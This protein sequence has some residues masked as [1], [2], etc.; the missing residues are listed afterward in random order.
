MQK[1]SGNVDMAQKLFERRLL[2]HR[3]K[4]S[5]LTIFPKPIDWDESPASLKVILN[6][7]LNILIQF[8]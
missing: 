8:S 1:D 7:Y 2:Y 3:V 4:I 6:V 5:L